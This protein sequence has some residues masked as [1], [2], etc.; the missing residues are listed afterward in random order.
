LFRFLLKNFPKVTYVRNI[1]DVD[2][3]INAQAIAK[4]V[5]IQKLTNDVLKTFYEDISALNVLPPTFEPKATQHIA[6]MIKMIEIL[7][8]KKH[9]YVSDGHV[10]FNVESYAEYGELSNRDIN[11]M[12]SG[13]RVEIASYKKSPLDF[14][15]WK[16]AD[17]DD[18]IS[19]VFESPWGNGRPGWHIECSAMSNKYLSQNFDIH[20]GGCDLQFPHHENE[21]AQ[22]KCANPNSTYAKYWVHNGFLTVNGE[23]M[24]KSLNNFFT[25]KD[26]LDKNIQPLAIRYLLLATHYRKPLDFNDKAML[27][28]AKA[29]EKF[30]DVIENYQK[31]ESENL[32]LNQIIES[33]ADDL[34]SPLAFSVLHE[35]VKLIKNSEGKEKQ[36][37][38]NNLVECLDFLGLFD[39]NYFSKLESDS[40]KNGIAESY[41]LEKI[42]A[43]RIA[44]TQKNWA[45]ADSI[46]QELL[47]KN[48]VIEDVSGGEV[49]WHYTKSKFV[50]SNR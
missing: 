24:S 32:Y 8:D 44:K 34:N 17:E 45:L 13:A 10:L 26:L 30:Y 40:S 12:I 6:E 5:S 47:D 49:K 48:I 2:D 19:S 38:V 22:S 1:T 11:D 29:I 4:G 7:I 35:V 20:G 3:K 46:R 18:D 50:D 14:V 41:I 16:P 42:S 31:I 15:L 21:I 33:L 9:A 28:A 25:I 27:D 23:K 43:R 39:A 36:K 37:L